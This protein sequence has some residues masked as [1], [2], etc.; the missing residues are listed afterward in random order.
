MPTLAS[1]IDGPWLRGEAISAEAARVV[2]EA[3]IFEHCKWDPQ[4][5][6]VPVLHPAALILR[7]ETWNELA[8]LAENM[9]AEIRE[10]ERAILAS[11]AALRELGLPWSLRRALVSAGAT[12]SAADGSFRVSRFDF[13][14]T[15][16]GW[17]VSEVNSDVPG[18]YIESSGFAAEMA[19]HYPSATPTGDPAA[20]LVAALRAA[21]PTGARVGLVHA[22]AYTDDRQV[23]V[24][25]SRRLTAAGFETVLLAPDSLR[26][27]NGRAETLDGGALDHLFRFFPA[28]W[29]PNL[30]WR[31]GWKN[32]T[33][34]DGTPQANPPSAIVS[35]SKRFPLACR[36][37][38]LRLPTWD[39]LVPETRDPRQVQAA[40]LDA[41]VLKP[42]LG[43]VGEDIGI[44]GATG[45]RELVKI[46]RAARRHAPHWAAQRR[47][48]ALP[49]NTDRGVFFP[50]IGVYVVNGLAAGVYGR[51]APRPLIDSH[52]QDVAVLLEPTSPASHVSAEAPVENFP[53]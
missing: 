33:R 51:V 34:P 13:H 25:L 27:R 10:A 47:F 35:Q 45:P 44:A 41:W 8:Q 24:F 31:S 11:P 40:E 29:L 36:R 20:A 48:S 3:M 23:M 2:R 52:A 42:A 4:V 22:T 5:G 17:R 30:G 39:A 26:W 7:R 9:D 49:W 32:F 18:G 1:Q 53:P 14:H 43:R 16:E 19:A 38:G 46:R 12:S 6:D 21:H 15:G 37:L 50:C 28:E